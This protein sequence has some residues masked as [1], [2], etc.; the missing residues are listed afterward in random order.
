VKKVIKK[1]LSWLGLYEYLQSRV[2]LSQLPIGSTVLIHIGKCGGR[3]VKDGV[4]NAVHNSAT[5]KVH[6]RKP[7][8]RKDLNYII[9]ARGPVSRLISA[10][11]WRYKLVVSDGGQRDRFEGEYDVLIKYG[12]LNNLAEA[13][14]YEN[15][16]ANLIAQQEIRKI[17]HI[18]EDISFYLRDLL[19][20][21]HPSQ[22]IAVLMQENLD[23]DIFRV[24]GYRNEFYRHRNPASAED[25]ELSD[26]GLKNLMRFFEEDYEALTKLYCWGKIDRE[27]IMKAL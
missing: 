27:V 20:R 10:F 7:I 4:K 13:L 18:R 14:Y 6:A 17:H 2:G 19:S 1:V 26:T 21:C 8:Y 11:R 15:G 12:S 5:H 9:I 22:I 24:F 16:E 3:T 23:E 25:K